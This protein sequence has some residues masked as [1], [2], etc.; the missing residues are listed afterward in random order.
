MS[1][2]PFC[3]LKGLMP[4]AESTNAESPNPISATGLMR[5]PGR[6]SDQTVPL[7]WEMLVELNSSPKVSW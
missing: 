6:I 7:P 1:S 3:K 2:A 5:E 4:D